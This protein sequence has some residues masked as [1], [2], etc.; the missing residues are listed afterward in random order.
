MISDQLGHT[1]WLISVFPKTGGT[2]GKEREMGKR[3]D[4]GSVR[5][6]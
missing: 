2:E 5:D 4:T 3:V 6:G 1:G